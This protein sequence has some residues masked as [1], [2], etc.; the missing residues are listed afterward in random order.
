MIYYVSTQ[1]LISNT[2]NI[3]Q[4]PY[5]VALTKLFLLDWVSVDTETQ[6]LD[7]FQ[8]KIIMLQL[9]NKK[10]Q[11]I[12]DTTTIDILL[13]KELLETKN[14]ILQNAKF[15]LQFFYV[16]GIVPKKKI[17]DTML[18]EQVLYNGFNPIA[19]LYYLANK[20]C[21]VILDKAERFNFI[22]K[23]YVVTYNAIIYGAK[24]IEYLEFIKESQIIKAKEKKI[25]IAIKLEN[26]FVKVLAY[27]EYCGIH[28]DKDKW[29]NKY[30]TAKTLLREKIVKL[31]KYVINNKLT[32][33]ID[34]Q[35]NLF[36]TQRR[37]TIN[38]ASSKQVI[39]L[40][41]DIG[42]NI[43]SDDNKSGKSIAEKVI[44]RQED[45]F[46]IIPLYLEYQNIK[47]DFTTYGEKFLQ[48]I[49]PITDRIHSNFNQLQVTS[50]LSSNNP[51]MQNLP[52]DNR[53]RSC[54]TAKKGNTL[55]DCDYKT[56]E[57]IL[58]VNRSREPKMIEFFQSDFNDGHS[59]VAKLCFPKELKDIPIEQ[60][61]K[62][63]PKLRQESKRA[64][65][66]IHYGGTGYTIAKNLNLSEEEGNKIEK[67]YLTAFP[68]IHSYLEKV[69]K[70]A[71]E[72]KYILISAAT[73]RKF[74]AREFNNMSYYEQKEFCKLGC[75]Y[76]IQGQSAELTKL[77]AIYFFKWVLEKNYFDI[78]EIC[79]LVHDEILVECPI[80]MTKEVSNKLKE[81]LEKGAVPYTKIV[82]LTAD[83][84]IGSFWKH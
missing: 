76:P 31:E 54:F 62:K 37:T 9:G 38:W 64:K 18:A 28:L 8:H 51:N 16:L 79:N 63:A 49:N 68:T 57:D 12:I 10:E 75:N 26:S 55:I 43:N 83:I 47:K 67:A 22:N 59:Y 80:K 84:E 81:C 5:K 11:F 82:P 74:W 14:L 52:A 4:I 32:K 42:I 60:V 2:D 41:E 25:L 56:Q 1:K 15:D 23:N 36:S 30:T 50:R 73:G 46:E 39:P 72:R 27:T 45:S 17:W 70:Q 29:I 13:F 69:K 71:R 66:A 3:V 7:R 6:G 34:N 20:Y 40:F 24:D 48:H 44:K 21:N 77:G 61:K 33:Y 19:N 58:F 78:V 65:F 35:L 53:T